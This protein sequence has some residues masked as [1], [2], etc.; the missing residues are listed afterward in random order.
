M[1]TSAQPWTIRSVVQWSAK[2]FAQRG[3]PSP[4]LDAELLVAHALGIDRV[5]LY[6]D[7]DRP[8]SQS[9]RGHIRSLVSRRQRREPVAYILGRK[10]FYGRSFIV[11]KD[12]LIPRPETELIVELALTKTW[13]KL[14]DICTGSGA[15]GI[16]MALERP[17]TEVTLSDVSSPALNVARDNAAALGATHVT[18]VESDLFSSLPTAAR[19]DCITANPPYIEHSAIASLMTDV[20]D[21]E[22]TIALESGPDGLACIGRILGKLSSHLAENGTLWMEIGDNQ[23]PVVQSLCAQHQLTVQFHRDL[24]QIERVAQIEIHH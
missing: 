5:R 12:V 21:Y 4:R 3:I 6:M 8:L 22:P 1:S 17:E 19:F 2:D 13:K 20:K 9:E 14:L 10:E 23:A 15:I 18:L 16:T 24:Q 11:N 7:L